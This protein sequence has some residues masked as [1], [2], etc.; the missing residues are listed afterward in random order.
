[1]SRQIYRIECTGEVREV[2]LV[3]AESEEEA[4][5]E[6]AEGELIVQES[7]GVEPVS[8]RLEE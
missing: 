5:A 6:W 2:Y 4:R 7:I 3:E 8:V 1:M